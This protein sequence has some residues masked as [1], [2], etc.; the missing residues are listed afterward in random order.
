[1]APLPPLT[2]FDVE[3]TGLDPKK[4]HRIVEI[5]GVRLENGTLRTDSV[6]VEM[7]NPE[8]EIPWEARQVNKISDQEVAGA[9][10]IEQVLPRFLD[11]AGGSILVAH[12]AQFDYGFLEN[13]KQ[14]CWGYVE[15]P[16]CLCTMRLFQNIYPGEFRSNLDVVCRKFSLQTPPMRHRALADAMLTGQALLQMIE[17]GHISSMD[18]LRKRA[19]IK[20]MVL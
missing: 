18:E 5:A 16:D 2:V 13:E 15:L 8:R 12:N 19:A 11:F 10:T 14:F 7:V 3:T 1:M 9:P 20:Q 6:F 4:G 17:H